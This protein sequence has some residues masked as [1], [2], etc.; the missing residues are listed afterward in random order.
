MAY[1]IK[2]LRE[3][4]RMSQERLAE[5]SGI[6]R[7]TIVAL[8]NNAEQDAKAGTLKALAKAFEV[9]VSELFTDTANLNATE[10]ETT[11]GA[12]K[13]LAKALNVSPGDLLT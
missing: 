5:L 12:L 2:E 3:K 7:G 1:R 10:K 9:P 11:V 13:T 8:E 6:S 4:N